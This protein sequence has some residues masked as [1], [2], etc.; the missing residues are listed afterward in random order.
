MRTP[1]YVDYWSFRFSDLLRVSFGPTREMKSMVAYQDWVTKSI[2]TNKPY[3]QMARE[4]IASQGYSAP[5]R[6]FYTDDRILA[7]EIIMP[8]MV[9]VFWGRRIE[10]AQCH[11]HPFETWTQKQFWEL[12]AFFGGMTELEASHILFD[13]LGG[14]HVDKPRELMVVNPRT[15]E[16]VVPAFLDGMNLPE[17]KCVDPRLRF[18]QGIVSHPFFADAA[19]NRIWSY[20]FGRGIVDPVDDFRSTNPPT[21]PELLAALAKDFKDSGYDLKHLIRVI[22]QSRTYQ[23]SG[24]PTEANKTDQINYSHAQPRHLEAAVLLDAITSATGASEH[25]VLQ[26]AGGRMDHLPISTRAVEVVPDI[27]PSPFLDAFG[28]SKRTALP[29]GPPQ[30][31][32]LEA[33]DMLAGTTYTSKITQDGGR[34][35]R[36][37]KKNAPD[38][39]IIDEFYLASLTRYP[40]ANEKSQLLD[41][42]SRR[43]SNHREALADLVWALISSREFTYN[44]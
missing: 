44:H 2:A 29:L 14:H 17:S 42:I 5:S 31:N 6:N 13:V 37:L 35:D 41:F 25:F 4:R 16:K 22:V 9:R 24:T 36:L 8:E 43:P 20:F 32:L 12:T 34:L 40:T 26:T 1:E 19:V 23:L 39:E 28:R 10:C 18:A 15:K 38:G 30:P 21:H 27:C 11:N 3:D 33:L 7:P